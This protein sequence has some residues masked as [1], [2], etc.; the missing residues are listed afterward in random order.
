MAI[1]YNPNVMDNP[2]TTLMNIC[3]ADPND[4]FISMRMR[5]SKPYDSREDALKDTASCRV[6]FYED[7]ELYQANRVG[8]WEFKPCIRVEC[9]GGINWNTY[10]APSIEKLSTYL[11]TRYPLL[12]NFN[13]KINRYGLY[14]VQVHYDGRCR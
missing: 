5:L 1:F 3:K 10:C 8:S 6:L 4:R 9:E 7:G 12:V 13:P 2:G 14:E 11:S